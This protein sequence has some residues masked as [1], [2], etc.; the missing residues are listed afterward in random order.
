VSVGGWTI[1][2]GVLNSPRSGGRVIYQGLIC[3]PRRVTAFR[4]SR[5]K[6]Q[7]SPHADVNRWIYEAFDSQVAGY[8]PWVGI[9]TG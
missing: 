6:S 5:G 9:Y 3:S 4:R 7:L 2:K 1:T 8:P